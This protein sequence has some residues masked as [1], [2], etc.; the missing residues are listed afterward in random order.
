[1]TNALSYVTTFKDGFTP[2]SYQQNI[3]DFVINNLRQGKNLSVQAVAG[4]GKSKTGLKTFELL[5]DDIDSQFVAFNRSIADELATKL[6]K[7]NACTYHSLGSRTL[8]KTFPKMVIKTDKVETFLRKTYPLDRWLF[9][10]VK[11]LVGLCKGMPKLDYDEHDL[12]RIAFDHDVDLYPEKGASI[13]DRI[14][15]LTLD[16][17]RYSFNTPYVVDFDDM[18][19]LPNVLDTVSFYQFDFLFVDEAQDTNMSQSNLAIRSIKPD[20]M[21]V[22]VGDSAQSIYRFRGADSTAMERLKRELG[23]TSLPLSL[24]YRCP[25]K[26]RDLV[27]QKFPNIKFETPEWAIE[28]NIRDVMSNKVETVIQPDDLVLCRVNADLVPLAFSLLRHD[29]KATIKGRDIGNGLISLIKKSNTTETIDLVK[30][31]DDWKEA[32]MYKAIQLN[33]EEKIQLIEDRFETLYAMTEGTT[34]VT[35]VVRRCETLFSDERKGVLLSTV[36]RAKGLEADNV[37]ILRPD[38][39]PHPAAKK[40]NSPENLQQE[41]NLEYVAITRAKKELTYIL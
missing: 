10:S 28:G 15:E 33:R 37:F 5:P 41:S 36:H 24:S 22:V 6:P 2:S 29:I 4:S 21:I 27:N 31:M 14:F 7:Q 1:M 18:I 12:V 26:I 9:Y 35:E 23:A 8:R 20:G 19:W 40:S 25:T 13:A 17:L 38:L 16:A 3:F 30:W 39:I 11:K 32:E 34:S